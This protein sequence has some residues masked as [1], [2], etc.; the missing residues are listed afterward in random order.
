LSITPSR[1]QTRSAARARKQPPAP[2]LPPHR[3]DGQL[4]RAAQDGLGQVVD[5]VD[6]GPRFVGRTLG[7]LDGVEMDAVR[8]EIAAA[9]QD[10]DAGSAALPPIEGR[11]QAPALAVLI[12][13]L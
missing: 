6:V 11:G 3:G 1:T 13:P 5:G 8:P 9:A 2:A 10:D 7:R 12:A 4:R